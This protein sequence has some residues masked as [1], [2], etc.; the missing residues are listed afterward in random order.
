[1]AGGRGCPTEYGVREGVV[2]AWLV[3]LGVRLVDVMVTVAGFLFLEGTLYTGGHSDG[4]GTLRR[5]WRGLLRRHLR[6]GG[7]RLSM[8]SIR[9]KGQSLCGLSNLKAEGKGKERV[10]D[11][12][13][14][15]LCSHGLPPH[16]S[17]GKE[18]KVCEMRSGLTS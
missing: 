15:R 17:P 6:V 8:T 13:Q 18:F 12:S 5:V 14:L 2:V 9:L 3:L 10:I 1:M 11:S 7:L 4:I 16:I